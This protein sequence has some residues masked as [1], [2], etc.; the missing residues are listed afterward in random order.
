MI[1][2]RSLNAALREQFG[3][4]LAL[5]GGFTCPTRDG[6]LDTRGCIFCEGGS[7]AFAEPVG[8]DVYAAIERSKERVADKG[9]KKYIA[10]YQSYTG[11]YAPIARLRQLYI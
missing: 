7:G 3:D 6:T 1:R 11:T 9:G 4:K 10:Y 2:Y 5:D 8:T